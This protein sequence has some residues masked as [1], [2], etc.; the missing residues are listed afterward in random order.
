MSE[1]RVVSYASEYTV[2][3]VPDDPHWEIKVEYRGDHRWAVKYYGKCLGRDG[4]W[5]YESIVSEREEQWLADHRFPLA[6]ALILAQ[7]HA[8][9]IK[10]NGK[11]PADWL[12]R[13][14]D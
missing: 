2:T 6:E 5:S 7:D 11:T 8:P 13:V 14:T 1:L 9:L 10:V 3:C 4:T 12:H